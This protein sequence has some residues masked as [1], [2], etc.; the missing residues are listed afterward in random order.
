MRISDNRRLLATGDRVT[1]TVPRY[2]RTSENTHIFLEYLQRN[3]TY[4]LGNR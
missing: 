3:A 1:T 2:P 4:P